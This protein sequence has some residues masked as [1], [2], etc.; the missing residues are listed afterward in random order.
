MNAPLADMALILARLDTLDKAIL[1]LH[2][3]PWMTTKEAAAFLRCSESKIN[4]LSDTCLLPYRRLDP[5]APR[6]TRLY[7]RKH[8]T[9]YLMAGRNPVKH[10]LSP[11]EKRLVEELL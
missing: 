4:Q 2:V 9:A 6:S 8:L 7:H 11:E 3:S 1:G 10:R 5:T